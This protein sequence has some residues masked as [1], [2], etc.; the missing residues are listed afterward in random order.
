MRS[1]RI[2]V[3]FLLLFSGLTLVGQRPENSGA[4]ISVEGVVTAMDGAR[5]ISGARVS[6]LKDPGIITRSGTSGVDLPPELMEYLSKVTTT[7]EAGH[8]KFTD[9]DPKAFGLVVGA[10]G[11]V[12]QQLELSDFPGREKHI[13][14]RL[15][16]TGAI[17]GVV[18]GNGSRPLMNVQV[19]LL[20]YVYNDMGQRS[21]KSFA[22]TQTNN[23]GEYRFYFI[24]PGRYLLRSGAPASPL[25]DDKETVSP[26]FYPGVEDP[27]QSTVVDIEPGMDRS[28][29]DFNLK[30]QQTYKI[31]GHLAGSPSVDSEHRRIMLRLNYVPEGFSTER[32][33]DGNYGHAK[34]SGDGTFE[35]RDLVPG[36][37]VVTAS[38]DGDNEIRALVPVRVGN[39]N[40]ENV[41]VALATTAT[42]KGRVRVDGQP[43]DLQTAERL[44]FQLTPL[45]GGNPLADD[46]EIGG[47]TWNESSEESG[48]FAVEDVLPLDYKF[49]AQWVP[50]GYYVKDARFGQ[51]DVLNHSFHPYGGDSVLEIVFSSRAG[52]IS[53]TVVDDKSKPVRAVR[54]V[55]VPDRARDRVDL[56]EN[57]STNKDGE[58]SFESVVPGDYKLFVWDSTVERNSWF[59]PDFIRRFEPTATAVHVDESSQQTLQLKI[60]ANGKK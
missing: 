8:F 50:P 17:S 18:R 22:S 19:Q 56:Y 49:Q 39:G 58:F 30:L 43:M 4:I 24:T 54:T 41:A 5:P 10:N 40:V 38:A 7:D 29:F 26:V 48:E 11:F 3:S 35:F 59:D 33:F 13:A 42:V 12:R 37:Y 55:L 27:R 52:K 6:L 2:S 28:G 14:V 15:A 25:R 32:R 36:L 46:D 47:T 16:A 9:I 45:L 20:L 1:L 44:R 21:L 53:G 23:A 60:A 57:A 34:P 51:I 31:R